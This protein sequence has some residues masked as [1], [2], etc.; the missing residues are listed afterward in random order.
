MTTNEAAAAM[1]QSDDPASTYSGGSSVV[2]GEESHLA[3]SSARHYDHEDSDNGSSH[4]HASN[5][6]DIGALDHGA[7]EIVSSM[8]VDISPPM[9]PLSERLENIG[10]PS[11]LSAG[12]GVDDDGL[13][14]VPPVGGRDSPPIAPIHGV[15]WDLG[16]YSHF[17]SSAAPPSTAT[18]ATAASAQHPPSSGTGSSARGNDDL[19]NA[20]MSEAAPAP[21][22][23]AASST[24]HLTARERLVER[25]RQSRL[26]RQRAQVK[27]RIA[28]NREAEE[29]EL[30][31][32]GIDVENDDE[33]LSDHNNH[34]EGSSDAHQRIETLDQLAGRDGSI[35]G[36]VG[37]ASTHGGDASTHGG[38]VEH[39]DHEYDVSVPPPGEV[40]GAAA[41]SGE[42]DQGGLA[43]GYAMERFLSEQV[44]VAD[45]G[46]SNSLGGAV[47]SESETLHV[48]NDRVPSTLDGEVAATGMSNTGISMVPD[49]PNVPNEAR[50]V[51][52]DESGHMRNSER[53]HSPARSVGVAPPMSTAS[54]PPHSNES[55]RSVGTSDA[56]SIGEQIMPSP[57]VRA[58]SYDLSTS[59]RSEDGTD[60]PNDSTDGAN[61]AP[62]LARL[63]EA[64]ISEMNTLDNAS[65]G[66]VAPRS[67]RDEDE[68]LL[69]IGSFTDG[70]GVSVAGTQTTAVE[71]V[72]S[73]R[74]TAGG[75]PSL[76][77]IHSEGDGEE[78]DRNLLT[79]SPVAGSTDTASNSRS[80]M[81]LGM[82][83]DGQ[84]LRASPLD[85]DDTPTSPHESHL[86]L[87]GGSMMHSR[88]P[89]LIGNTNDLEVADPISDDYDNQ[90]LNH[91]EIAPGPEAIEGTSP[92]VA[93]LGE[94]V[95]DGIESPER[96]ACPLLDQ[97][98]NG[99]HHYGATNDEE[100]LQHPPLVPVG[101]LG[102]RYVENGGIPSEV[103]LEKVENGYGPKTMSIQEPPQDAVGTSAP[104]LKAEVQIAWLAVAF[105]IG[106]A[107]GLFFR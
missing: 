94:Y 31:R 36:T 97:G 107:I 93:T 12:R 66:N 74:S 68:P 53:S 11:A 16:D 101:H 104:L 41:P 38:D 3:S 57:P 75:R 1:S 95:D 67:I 45:Q 73:V 46:Q 52:L 49:G 18:A 9:V 82:P 64:D 106:L 2:E 92:A 65:V 63:T 4:R 81:R 24:Q 21:A 15:R 85:P 44:V 91:N 59:I 71:T 56:G 43:L 80:S 26:E 77:S 27:R 33:I 61:F 55:V 99:F 84:G 86:L 40:V 30:A 34:G 79:M 39:H 6:S 10:P 14:A 105:C 54:Y 35:V 8:D 69:R 100:G 70:I 5:S 90:Y 48:E 72:S 17:A 47:G 23:G 76:S 32:A 83:G 96:L 29:M 51:D 42:G 89:S 37:D 102:S 103:L 50:L 60:D 7:P 25:E 87:A 19:S 88:S 62:R 58:G 28:M 98:A 20:D 22:A 78:E 13:V